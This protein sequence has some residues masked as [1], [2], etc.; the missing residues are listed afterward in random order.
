MA[1]MDWSSDEKVLMVEIVD[2]VVAVAAV[3]GGR[4]PGHFGHSEHAVIC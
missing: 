1:K 3:G 2:S 4:P